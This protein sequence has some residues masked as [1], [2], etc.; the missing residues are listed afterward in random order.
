VISRDP[1]YKGGRR[2][3][4]R[5]LTI[6]PGPPEQEREASSRLAAGEETTRRLVAGGAREGVEE[7][8]LDL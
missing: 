4:D 8:D 3:F 1:S 6:E 5:A 2:G 7:A